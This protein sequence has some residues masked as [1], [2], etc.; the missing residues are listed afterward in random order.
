MPTFENVGTT[1]HSV[2]R[3]N[4]TPC[5]IITTIDQALSWMNNASTFINYQNGIGEMQLYGFPIL[6]F[7]HLTKNEIRKIFQEFNFIPI[8]KTIII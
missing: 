3:S 4:F 8:S 6:I 1:L 2:Y 7:E 5:S